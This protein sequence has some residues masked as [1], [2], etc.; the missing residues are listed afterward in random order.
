LYIGKYERLPKFGN[1]IKSWVNFYIK[2]DLQ[3]LEAAYSAFGTS[4]FGGDPDENRREKF[5]QLTWVM[6]RKKNV[7]TVYDK[8]RAVWEVK[9]G[10]TAP[11]T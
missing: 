7:K 4:A 2:T 8:R 1:G 6:L 5:E 9:N 10:N 3:L 11:K